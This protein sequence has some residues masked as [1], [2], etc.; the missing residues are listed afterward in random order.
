MNRMYKYFYSSF[1]MN[2]HGFFTF[3]PHAKWFHPYFGFFNIGF[4][5]EKYREYYNYFIKNKPSF[6][7]YVKLYF[8]EIK[9]G[10][11]YVEK[12][13]YSV[14]ANPID[15]IKITYKLNTNSDYLDYV[16]IKD[17]IA[18]FNVDIEVDKNYI[19]FMHPVEIYCD[20]IDI[21][22]FEQTISI[23]DTSSPIRIVPYLVAYKTNEPIYYLNT[24]ANA[25]INMNNMN[26]T[27][28]LI[29]P[30]D[31]KDFLSKFNVECLEAHPMFTPDEI[32]KPVY[33]KTFNAFSTSYALEDIEDLPQGTLP[34]INSAF[35]TS[36]CNICKKDAQSYWYTKIYDRNFTIDDLPNV[37]CMC[38]I[39][40][41]TDETRGY[42]WYKFLTNYTRDDE[43]LL[44]EA[45]TKLPAQAFIEVEFFYSL[46]KKKSIKTTP[47]IKFY[48]QGLDNV[49]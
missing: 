44:K 3:Y 43:S 28:T 4:P 45:Y 34:I 26:L 11:I 14:R 24:D 8:P 2:K 41:S 17:H 13:K 37:E 1:M 42:V 23:V 39:N 33:L 15:D 19:G 6:K 7:H 5:L 18:E 16:Q 32:N 38:S 47:V 49:W 40:Y 25:T 46:Y 12:I 30:E 36:S 22:L 29:F 10:V 35:F 21:K 27:Y 20:Y 48:T 31:S 9:E